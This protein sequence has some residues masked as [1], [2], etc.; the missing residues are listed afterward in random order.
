M[1]VPEVTTLWR[2]GPARCL[3]GGVRTK[4]VAFVGVKV[5]AVFLYVD[6][7]AAAKELGV[8]DRGGFFEGDDDYAAALA[9]GAFVKALRI[10]LVRDVDGATFYGA[11]EDALAPRLRLTGDMDSLGAFRD[12]LG[13]KKLAKGTALCLLWTPD[14]ALEVAASTGDRAPA[15]FAA[16]DAAD[17]RIESAGLARALFEVYLGSAPASPG[18]RTAWA[19]G[20]RALL[21]TETVKRDTR[22]SGGKGT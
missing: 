12:Y 14:G 20:A 13:G 17:L 2:G 11:L 3:G 1:A 18:A 7:A 4:K 16:P 8:R 15:S 21:A 22:K 6:A 19:A 5:Y 10:D 9:D